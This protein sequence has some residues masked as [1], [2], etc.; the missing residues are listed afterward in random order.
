MSCAILRCEKGRCSTRHAPIV[1]GT[2]RRSCKKSQ[3]PCADPHNPRT[4]DDGCAMGRLHLAPGTRY[5]QGGQVHIMRQLLLDGRLLVE[6][7]TVGG[8]SVLARDEI[9]AA[10]GREAITILSQGFCALTFYASA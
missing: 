1:P 5:L 9:V 8:Q 4:H 7:Q 3:E 10:W 2:L 6:N